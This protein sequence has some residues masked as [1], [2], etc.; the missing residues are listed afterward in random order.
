MAD[1]DAEHERWKFKTRSTINDLCDVAGLPA[2]YDLSG[3]EPGAAPARILG[4]IRPDEFFGKP[5]ATAVKAALNHLRSVGRAPAPVEAIYEVLQSGGFEFS[6]RSKEVAIQGLSVSIGKNSDSFVKLPNGLI[7][8][9]EWYGVSGK[10]G[11][12]KSPGSAETEDT[13][14][15]NN[16]PTDTPA[17]SATDGDAQPT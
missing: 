5:L 13:E 4:T 16:E 10:K 11:R 12:T 17:D 3:G 2:K 15:T 9:K 7:G 8:V 14:D 6:S 1:R